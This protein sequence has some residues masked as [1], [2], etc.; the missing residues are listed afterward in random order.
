MSIRNIL[1]TVLITGLGL[2]LAGFGALVG[3]YFYVSGSLPK[4]DTLAD[5]QPPIISRVFSD[6]GAVIAEFYRE[7]RIVV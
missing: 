2:G 5:Y 4:V 7:R 6:D 3:A 1:R